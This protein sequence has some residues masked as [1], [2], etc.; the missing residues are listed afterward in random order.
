MK[1]GKYAVDRIEGGLAVLISD[2]DGSAIHLPSDEHGLSVN[3]L[4]YLE[5]D[6]GRLSSLKRLDGE[7]EARLKKNKSRLEALFAKG[8]KK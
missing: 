7:K 1:N 4:V 3:D 6:N 8:R 5:F 2:D